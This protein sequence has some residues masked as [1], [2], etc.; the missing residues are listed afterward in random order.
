ML[1]IVR[2]FEAR[3]N[4]TTAPFAAGFN[5]GVTAQDEFVNKLPNWSTG[6]GSAPCGL[7]LTEKLVSWLPPGV[8][9]EFIRSFKLVAKVGPS[10][11]SACAYAP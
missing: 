6:Q 7:T 8:P 5:G 2:F 1:N 11:S 10:S 4:P 9:A 3:N